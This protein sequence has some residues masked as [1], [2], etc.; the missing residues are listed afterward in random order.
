MRHRRVDDPLA[1]HVHD[2]GFEGDISGEE[3]VVLA[4]A[5]PANDELLTCVS[6]G[7][8]DLR[9]DKLQ[10][11]DRGLAYAYASGGVVNQDRFAFAQA[12]DVHKGMVHRGANHRQ[13][14]RVVKLV[15]SGI[16]TTVTK[17]AVANA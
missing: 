17:A 11:H 4:Q 2:A 10:Q 1:C 16:R 5:V 8:E 9:P 14:R 12:S 15:V 7:G 6:D 13:R 3:D